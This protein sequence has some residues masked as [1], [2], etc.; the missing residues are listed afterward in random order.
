MMSSFEHIPQAVKSPEVLCGAYF[1]EQA[2][3]GFASPI[4][5]FPFIPATGYKVY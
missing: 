3:M 2:L 5:R 1:K 4:L